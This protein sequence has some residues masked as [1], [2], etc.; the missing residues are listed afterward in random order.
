MPNLLVAVPVS[1]CAHLAGLVFAG[2][3]V[4]CL[5]SARGCSCGLVGVGCRCRL[6]VGLASVGSVAL[7]PMVVKLNVLGVAGTSVLVLVSCALVCPS[8]V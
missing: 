7:L 6:M 4:F 3:C 1:T 8:V 2:L 5:R